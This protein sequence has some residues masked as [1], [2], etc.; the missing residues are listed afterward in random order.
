MDGL[1][2]AGADGERGAAAA[3]LAE[4]GREA[5]SRGRTAAG[6]GKSAAAARKKPAGASSLL[7]LFSPAWPGVS[8]PGTK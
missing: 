8:A 3:R 7:S 4:D 5:E 1:G 6:E 2:S